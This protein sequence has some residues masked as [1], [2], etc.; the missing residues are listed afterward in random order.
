MISPSQTH[1]TQARVTRAERVFLCML[2]YAQS[3]LRQCLL[4][5]EL[6]WGTQTVIQIYT[7]IF[8]MSK[9]SLH[10]HTPGISSS[11]PSMK[12]AHSTWL[13]ESNH[14]ENKFGDMNIFS[15]F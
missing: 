1:T 2:L 9:L 10:A 7:P 5:K 15:P 4:I 13:A 14:R 8:V 11:V 6:F 3:F 12:K